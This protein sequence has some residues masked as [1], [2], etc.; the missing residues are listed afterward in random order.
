MAEALALLKKDNTLTTN[1]ADLNNKTYV[2]TG[3][4]SVTSNA[5]TTVAANNTISNTTGLSNPVA[6]IKGLFYSVQVGVYVRPVTSEQLFNITPLYDEIMANGYYKYLSGTYGSLQDAVAAKNSIVQKGVKD[7][8]VVVYNNGKKIT[9]AEAKS[10]L[11]GNAVIA[12][13]SETGNNTAI[14][15]NNSTTQNSNTEKTN[16]NSIV[17]E[18]SD[19]T[20]IVFKVQIGAFKNDVPVDIVNQLL[21]VVVGNNL[22]H[23]KNADGLTVYTSGN[24]KDYNSANEFK[25]SIVAKGVKD[26]FVVAFLNGQKIAV[27][28]AIE[29]LK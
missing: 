15:K 27:T 8:F 7:A 2:S 3:T 26:A 11:E 6:N 5:N 4:T 23:V 1:Y 25:N 12:N 16:N 9:L 10:L 18:S 21:D 24:F 22:E 29:L 19:K 13:T 28:K 20:G 17:K 14:E